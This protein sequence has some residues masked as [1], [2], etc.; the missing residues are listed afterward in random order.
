[1]CVCVCVCVCVCARARARACVRARARVC[2]CVFVAG[3][4]G[5]VVSVMYIFSDTANTDQSNIPEKAVS[6]KKDRNGHSN[7]NHACALANGLCCTF[8]I[9]T[10]IWARGERVLCVKTSGAW[11]AEAE[12]Q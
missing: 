6:S 8:T 12:K 11:K 2:A 7:N 4:V 5:V 9:G 1:M 3:R 10:G